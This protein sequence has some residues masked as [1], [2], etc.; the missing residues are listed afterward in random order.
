MGPERRAVKNLAIH[1]R[2]Y[3]LTKGWSQEKMADQVGADRTYISDIGRGLRNPSLKM[4]ARIAHRLKITIGDL[5]DLMHNP[6]SG[7][8]PEMSLS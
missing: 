8:K 1:L 3:R 6:M 7:Q 2:H 5:C 4:L